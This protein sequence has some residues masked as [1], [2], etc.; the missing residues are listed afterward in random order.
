M[1]I[2]SSSNSPL[3]PFRS[4]GPNRKPSLPPTPVPAERPSWLKPKWE[5][6]SKDA[7]YFDI[8]F[9]AEQA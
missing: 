6:S 1:S 7:A 5:G 4:F 8:E 3:T 2:P 9:I